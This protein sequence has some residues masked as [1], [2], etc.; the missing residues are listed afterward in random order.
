MSNAQ[1]QRVWD[2]T[3]HG[4]WLSLDNISTV[5]G[6]PVQSV[7]ARLRDF[8]KEKFGG[9][10]VERRKVEDNLYQYRVIPNAVH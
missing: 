2:A 1:R 9:H 3:N 4:L 5:T 6:D 10:T 7:S 8:R